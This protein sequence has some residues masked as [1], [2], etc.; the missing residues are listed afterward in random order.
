MTICIGR[1][2]EHQIGRN[3]D[4]GKILEHSIKF[5]EYGFETA[6]NQI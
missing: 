5:S 4:G 2:L 6:A 3:L 1:K